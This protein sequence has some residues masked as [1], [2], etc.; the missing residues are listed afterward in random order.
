MY[1]CTIV[2]MASGADGILTFLD[3]LVTLPQ[4]LHD[5]LALPHGYLGAGLHAVPAVEVATTTPH[6]LLLKTL[7]VVTTLTIYKTSNLPP[8]R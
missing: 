8:T 2:V 5:G 3:Q 4:A 6:H 1:C 7:R